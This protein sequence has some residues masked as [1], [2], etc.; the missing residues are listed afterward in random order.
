MP[1]TACVCHGKG[2]PVEVTQQRS[3]GRGHTAEVHGT[4]LLFVC[5]EFYSY[6]YIFENIDQYSEL[7][8][9][10]FSIYSILIFTIVNAC[11]HYRYPDILY[12][13]NTL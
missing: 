13:Y 5:I 8:Y 3:H 4:R 9:S 2:H 7:N 1:Y 12:I 11:I 6:S 10:T